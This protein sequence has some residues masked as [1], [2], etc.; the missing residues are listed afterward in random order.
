MSRHVST[1][2]TDYECLK[3]DSQRKSALAE[4]IGVAVLQAWLMNL[5]A[6]PRDGCVFCCA[7][8]Y[9]IHRSAAYLS[10]PALPCLHA[11]CA[12]PALHDTWPRAAQNPL[13][14]AS[15]TFQDHR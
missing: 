15:P 8:D 5:Q 9:E 2:K 3:E 4:V 11:C 10:L 14:E 6:K 1:C 12:L 13:V 7:Q